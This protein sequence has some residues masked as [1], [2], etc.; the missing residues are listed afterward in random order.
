MHRKLYLKCKTANNDYR[1]E[2][3]LCLCGCHFH[4]WAEIC[5][6]DNSTQLV[7]DLQQL[8][9]EQP[10]T[11]DKLLCNLKKKEDYWWDRLT[12]QNQSTKTSSFFSFS[13]TPGV[14]MD[15]LIPRHKCFAKF[16]G[17]KTLVTAIIATE[18]NS[19]DFFS[20]L[21]FLIIICAGI[22]IPTIMTLFLLNCYN[23]YHWCLSL[24]EMFISVYIAVVTLCG[25]CKMYQDS[26]YQVMYKQWKKH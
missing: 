6:W 2:P 12:T 3:C 24:L 8:S 17:K 13:P 23:R 16:L 22:V 9:W 25:V 15:I 21:F 11:V 26:I 7:A 14:F 5:S 18:D 4:T 10:W 1:V 20:S 19:R